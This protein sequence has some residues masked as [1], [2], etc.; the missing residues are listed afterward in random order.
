MIVLLCSL[1]V[2]GQQG[3][4]SPSPTAVVDQPRLNIGWAQIDI[5]PAVSE[6]RPAAV[7]G[8]TSLRLATQVDSPLQAT[9]VAIEA[10]Y[11]PGFAGATI[12]VG[13]DL[14]GINTGMM[15]SI[16]AALKESHPQVDPHWVIVNSTHTHNAPPLGAFGLPVEAMLEPEYIAFAAPRIAQVIAQ[17]WDSR[18]PGGISFGLSHAVI[19][20]NRIMAYESGRSIMGAPRATP[21]FS[22]VEGYEDPA[23]NLLYTWDA[24]G[25]ITGVVVNAAVTS[26]TMQSTSFISADF[27]HDT[28]LELRKR[29]G[30]KLFILPQCSSAGDQMSAAQVY[31][32]AEARMEKL[33]GRT[34]RQ[35]IAQRI[36]D[37]VMAIYPAMQA[38][39]EWSPL[40]AHRW[41]V[42][43]LTRRMIRPQDVQ[44]A[45]ADIEKFKPIYEKALEEFAGDP[46]LI[47]NPQ[48]VRQATAAHRNRIRADRV[49]KRYELQQTQPR[50]PVEAHSVRIGDMAL[51]TNPFEF[52]LDFGIQ[53]KVRSPAV[54]TFVVQMANGYDGYVPTARSV[55]G[56]AYGAVPA[57]TNVG[58]EGGKDMVEWAVKSIRELWALP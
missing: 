23:L 51:T 54:Q 40:L 42:V 8:M 19:G 36:A 14:R 4:A 18:Q 43:E 15:E 24:Q 1:P 56:G 29:L 28:R 50:F 27:W 41:E 17:A 21:D 3:S 53:I 34:R 33:T 10:P 25:Q 31:R 11:Q 57:S 38:N 49:L 37:G 44:D 30:E 16:R 5:T 6:A 20:H 55:A 2:L 7:A 22:H 12:L 46:G 39:I 48:W 52:Y 45:Q 26:Q 9:A 58:P 13:C 35:Q 47:N 32:R